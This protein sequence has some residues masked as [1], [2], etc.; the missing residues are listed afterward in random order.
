MVV[1]LAGV[2]LGVALLAGC[3]ATKP[4]ARQ[5]EERLSQLPPP[6]RLLAQREATGGVAR[7]STEEFDGKTVYRVRYFDDKA[8]QG[9]LQLT[10]DGRLLSKHVLYETVPFPQ[11]PEVVRAALLA[12]TGGV[13]PRT[14][15]HE[16]RGDASS[17]SEVYKFEVTIGGTEHEYVIDTTGGL[18]KQEV[19]IDPNHLPVAVQA[20]VEQRFNHPKL[21]SA[22]EIHRGDTVIYEVTGKASDGKGEAFEVQVMPDGTIHAVKAL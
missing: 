16:E 4:S 10:G 5:S 3:A 2:V 6:A 15:I 22:E 18:Y 13:S 8:R 9:E 12:R 19:V 20:A 1:G 14:A 21:D 11:V 7:V 17:S